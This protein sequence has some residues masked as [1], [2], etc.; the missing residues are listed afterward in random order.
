MKKGLLLIVLMVF[1]WVGMANATI[2]VSGDSNMGIGGGDTSVFMNNVFGGQDVLYNSS[3]WSIT[4]W[5]Q[6]VSPVAASF[7]LDTNFDAAALQT[8]DWFIAT[9]AYSYTNDEISLLNQFLDDGG[10]IFVV[11]EHPAYDNTNA[12]NLLSALGSTM[13]FGGEAAPR[14]WSS[15]GSEIGTDPFTTGVSLFT[16]NYASSVV[17]GGISLFSENSYTIV[18]YEETEAPPVPEPA[19][20]IL[21]G[22]GLAGLAFYRRK[23]K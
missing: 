20:F 21:L 12:N 15:T 4:N 2:M 3:H 10:S 6:Y 5:D 14:A 11:G 17:N 9:F 22:S 7:T 8:A 16:G 1:G 13:S 23:K 18:A 19:T